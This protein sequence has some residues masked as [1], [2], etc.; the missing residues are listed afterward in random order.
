MVE[1][2]R[3]VW[4]NSG[5]LMTAYH[6]EEWGVPVHDDRKLF[7][8]LI[9]EGAQAGLN[10]QTVLTKR[11]NYR[12]AFK[13]FNPLIISRY[14]EKEVK[15][16]LNNSGIIRNKLKIEATINNVHKLLE[17]QKEFGSFDKYVWDFVGGKP[18]R[19][20]WQSLKQL[21]SQTEQSDLPR[22]ALQSRG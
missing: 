7:E 13:N 18:L 15:E 10:W 19:N 11:E 1:K 5:E 6:D 21:P 17:V 12:R 8:F 3:C 4:A 2:K 16:L 14:G 20:R 22:N 9:L